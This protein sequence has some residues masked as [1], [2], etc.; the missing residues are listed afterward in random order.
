MSPDYGGY[1]DLPFVADFYDPVYDS[2]GRKDVQFYIDCAVKSGGSV[3]ELG[4]GTGRV[5]I[6]TA[7][8]GCKITGLDVSAYMLDKCREKLAGLPA[9]VRSRVRLV[10][11]DMTAFDTGEKYALITVP[12]RPFQHLI[13]VDEQKAC[14]A[15]VRKHLATGGRL[16]LDVYHPYLPALVDPKYLME[17]Q[18]DPEITLADGR[19]LRRTS[20]IAAFHRNEQFNDVELIHYVKYPDGRQGRLLHAFKM[21]YFYRYEM[22]HLLA[23]AGFKVVELFGNFDRSPFVS[24]SPEMIFVVEKV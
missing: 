14:L 1:N 20:R 24:E 18:V 6:P 9:D 12:F 2:L 8:A 5:L 10:Q 22:E 7:Q 3:L 13:V 17:M 21:R 4:C 16:V 11:A 23:L 19:I 15:C